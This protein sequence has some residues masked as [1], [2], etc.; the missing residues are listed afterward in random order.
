MM[1]CLW[2]WLE[3]LIEKSEYFPKV[4]SLL[5]KKV[6]C[7]FGTDWNLIQSSSSRHLFR[8]ICLLCFKL[9]SLLNFLVFSK[10]ITIFSNYFHSKPW[11]S[12][13]QIS[14]LCLLCQKL[15]ISHWSPWHL[16]NPG[17]QWFI[18]ML[19]S[20]PSD[21][22]STIL[23]PHHNQSV[24]MAPN[25][26]LSQPVTP[27]MKTLNCACAVFLNQNCP[28]RGLYWPCDFHLLSQCET[29]TEKDSA[30]IL[31]YSTFSIFIKSFILQCPVTIIYHVWCLDS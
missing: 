19:L 11:S 7:T 24:I 12:L 28:W 13:W 8:W 17:I 21:S 14:L 3:N 20:K 10:D 1:K 4:T 16:P 6:S 18:S 26:N 15:K 31:W 9:D 2:Y 23:Y 22:I 27:L 5:L 25:K 30:F 29:S